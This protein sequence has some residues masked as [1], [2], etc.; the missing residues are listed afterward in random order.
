MTWAA[1]LFVVAA[2]VVVARLLRVPAQAHAVVN[3][4]RAA[5][6]ALRDPG[7][8]ERQREQAARQHAGRLLWLCLGIVAATA[9][10]IAL[11]FGLVALLGVA[12]AVDFEAVVRCTVSPLFFLV[13][14]PLGTVTALL[15]RERRS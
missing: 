10:A 14:L 4:S 7:L 9:A 8:D 3:R 2:F 15:L 12:G 11:P 6:A 5:F 1:A 13:A